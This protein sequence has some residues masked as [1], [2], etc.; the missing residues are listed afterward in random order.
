MTPRMA[1]DVIRTPDN[2]ASV[3]TKLV[4][5]G[6]GEHARVVADAARTV[7]A[8]RL[9]GFVDPR[10]CMETVSRGLPRI[11]SEEALSAHADAL[12]ILGVGPK[13]RW[14]VREDIVNRLS[15]ERKWAVVTHGR[16]IIA[17]DVILGEG[18]VV[19]A[20]AVL[21]VGTHIGRHAVVNT[22]AIV[23]HDAQ[24]GDFAH[25]APGTTLGGRCMVGEG[26]YVGLGARVRDHVTIGRYAVVGMGAIVVSDVPDAAEVRGNPARAP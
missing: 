7:R 10:P 11:G 14:R 5:I 21:Q 17:P 2:E 22:G 23:E 26:A 8:L 3:T 13:P 18:T 6:G 25:L 16:A 20:G 15:S 9:E 19:M 1:K 12:L 24:V 4:I